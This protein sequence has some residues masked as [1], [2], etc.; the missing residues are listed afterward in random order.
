MNSAVVFG[1]IMY[2]FIGALGFLLMWLSRKV[3]HISSLVNFL[4]QDYVDEAVDEAI[5]ENTD[6]E[7]ERKQWI[8][9]N[10]ND[11]GFHVLKCP[12]CKEYAGTSVAN[13]CRMCGVGLSLPKESSEEREK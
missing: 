12:D 7:K 10:N 11:T 5:V 2:F 13:Y 6:K 4:M 3:D 8:L 1:I 9:E